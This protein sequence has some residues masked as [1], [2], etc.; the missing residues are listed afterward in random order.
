MS[1]IGGFLGFSTSPTPFDPSGL[2][3]RVTYLE[4]NEYKVAYYQEISSA[5]G[6]VTIPTNATLLPGELPSQNG[7]IVETLLDGKPS[8]ENP[9]DGSGNIIYVTSFDALGNYVLS[10]TPSAY[11]VALVFYLKIDAKY[12]QNLNTN[13]IIEGTEELLNTTFLDNQFTVKNAVDQTKSVMFDVSQTPTATQNIFFTPASGGYLL[14]AGMMSGGATVNN[15]GVVTLTNSAVTGQA[16]TGYVSSAGVIS[17]SDSILQAIQKLNGNISAL[18]TGVSSVSGTT[19]RITASPTSGAVTVD[20]ASTYVGQSSITTLGTIG[21]GVWQGTI[22]SPTYG[23]TGVNNGTNTITLG[24]TLETTG[25]FNTSFTQQFSGTIVL[26]PSTSTLAASTSALTSGRVP[27]VTTSGL[28][29]DSSRFAYNNTTQQLVLTNAT[30]NNL[31]DLSSSIVPA[32]QTG[33]FGIRIRNLA[34]GGAA[35]TRLQIANDNNSLLDLYLT[36]ASYTTTGLVNSSQSVLKGDTGDMLFISDNIQSVGGG[37]GKFIFAGGGSATSNELLGLNATQTGNWIDIMKGGRSITNWYNNGFKLT[38]QTSTAMATDYT[39][40]WPDVQGGASTVLTNNGS[41]V[42]NWSTLVTGVSSVT[43]TANRIT[44]SPTSGA[45]IVD[46]A[47]TYVGQSSIT[48]LGTIGTGT[49]QGTIVSPTYGGTGVNNGSNTITIAGNLATTGAFNTTFAQSVSATMTLPTVAANLVGS[50]GALTSGRIPFVTT[51]GVLTDSSTFLYN[52]IG[53]GIGAAPLG[54]LDLTSAS[55]SGTSFYINNNK[56]WRI[57]STGSANTGGAGQLG[58][59]NSTDDP[60]VYKI[61]IG[62][63][64]AT[65]ITASSTLNALSLSNANNSALGLLVQN[66]TSGS[67]AAS[68]LQIQSATS[69]LNIQVNSTTFT[70]AGL[71]VASQSYINDGSTNGTLFASTN[72]SAK[73][74]FAVGGTAAANEIMRMTSVGVNILGTA[75]PTSSLQLNGSFAPGYRTTSVATSLT[76]T[77]YTLK[78]LVGGYTVTLPTAVGITGRIYNIKKSVIGA[79]TAIT[80]ATTGGQTID[81]V[82]TQVLPSGSLNSITVQSDGANWIII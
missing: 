47:A 39:L 74:I 10:G 4:N 50:S 21:T 58:I 3:A 72:A 73:F 24:G 31:I 19:D 48:T 77:D 61:V 6:A 29:L 36:S 25:A 60:T 7:A 68:R 38:V 30:G 16:L 71:I 1:T 59:V 81:G 26:P 35:G 57:V 8:E 20:I 12:W 34:G 79:G 76:I 62:T 75:A 17:P 43:G 66:T 53:V 55:T 13:Y 37:V 40:T 9:T 5:S 49:W 78:C 67:A 65:T 64:G 44:T 42:L 46:I 18:V 2:N 45:V 32:N 33:L 82:A 22:V 11:P 14:T 23:G 28:L 80:V 51:N 27:F 69:L 15:S 56:S 52:G 41:G 63:S 70:T 54:L